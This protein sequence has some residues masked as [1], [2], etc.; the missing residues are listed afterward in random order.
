M[1]AG[2]GGGGGGGVEGLVSHCFMQV[3][4]LRLFFR[5]NRSLLFF[6]PAK[7]QCWYVW[8]TLDLDSKRLEGLRLRCMSARRGVLPRRWWQCCHASLT[9]SQGFVRLEGARSNC[10]T[11]LERC[12]F[13]AVARCCHAS[14]PWGLD[15]G[16]FVESWAYVH[17]LVICDHMLLSTD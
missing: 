8:G 16:S 3:T 14:L 15:T 2:G 11:G 13:V 9:Q 17:K 1:F 10:G 4:S 12:L 7:M 5:I 6:S